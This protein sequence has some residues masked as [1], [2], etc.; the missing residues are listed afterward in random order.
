VPDLPLSDI[1]QPI[2]SI[3]SG[4]PN[5]TVLMDQ[6]TDID[7]KARS[8]TL[9]RNTLSYDYLVLALAVARATSTSGV[10]RIRAWS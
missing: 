3:L 5:L 6:V 4:Q 2:R 8:V 10:G 1:A 7:L 9:E